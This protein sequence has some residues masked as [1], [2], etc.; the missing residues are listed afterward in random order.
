MTLQ[1][2]GYECPRILRYTGWHQV[3]V[4]LVVCCQVVPNISVI[5]AVKAALE[6]AVLAG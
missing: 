2:L 5:L 4:V 1:A 3:A 6:V